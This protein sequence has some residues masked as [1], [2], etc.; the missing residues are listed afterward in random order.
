MCVEIFLRNSLTVM[1]WYFMTVNKDLSHKKGGKEPQG[2][3][4]VKWYLFAEAVHWL[5]KGGS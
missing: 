4:Q 3:G 5:I 2:I 1:N